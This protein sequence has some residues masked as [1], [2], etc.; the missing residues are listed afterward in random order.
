MISKEFLLFAALLALSVIVIGLRYFLAKRDNKLQSIRMSKRLLAHNA[1]P[2][3]M[4]I[5]NGMAFKKIKLPEQAN[6]TCLK[7]LHLLKVYNLNAI[8][9]ETKDNLYLKVK[10]DHMLFAGDL[11]IVFGKQQKI[12]DFEDFLLSEHFTGRRRLDG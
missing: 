2:G 10:P 7:Q 11:L 8:A 4:P 9:V 6:R 3:Y 5:P 12:R 1:L